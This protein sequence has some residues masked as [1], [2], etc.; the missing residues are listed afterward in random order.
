MTIEELNQKIEYWKKKKAEYEEE[1]QKML[2]ERDNKYIFVRDSLIVVSDSALE[3]ADVTDKA[4]SA[5]AAGM[6]V[7]NNKAF[8]EDSL[9]K[10]TENM[11]KV[12][13]NLTKIIDHCDEMI[14]SLNN[15]IDLKT[16]DINYAQDKINEYAGY[17][18][19]EKSK[20]ANQFDTEK[21]SS[22]NNSTQTS[23]TNLSKPTFGRTV[24]TAEQR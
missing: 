4:L 17:V 23:T 22:K 3:L 14:N 16:N 13:D 9:T 8:E 19:A 20:M 24:I 2:E 21:P 7:G 12:S 10:H 15:K 1:K 18:L 5:L 11:V 6:V